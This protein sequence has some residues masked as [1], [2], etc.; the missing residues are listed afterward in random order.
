LIL[1]EN[2]HTNDTTWS[3]RWSLDGRENISHL[4]KDFNPAVNDQFICFYADDYPLPEDPP[5]ITFT[6]SST[7]DD[8][9]VGP[10]ENITLQAELTNYDN[11]TITATINI[12][13]VSRVDDDNAVLDENGVYTLQYEV[14]PDDI[15]GGAVSWL[16][17]ITVTNNSGSATDGR[18]GVIDQQPP[19]LETKSILAWATIDSYPYE[20][21]TLP[22]AVVAV[23]EWDGINSVK[24]TFDKSVTINGNSVT[25]YTVTES[26]WE[27]VFGTGQSGEYW[28]AWV[29]I[30]TW[31]TAANDVTV[32]SVGLGFNQFDFDLSSIN[33]L[34]G[35]YWASFSGN[36]GLY[37]SK[38]G[39][40][41][42]T[43]IQQLNNSS[44][45][46][47][48]NNYIP[49]QLN[50]TTRD[51]PEPSTLAIFALGMIGLA[52]RRFKKQS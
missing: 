48:T 12:D 11:G 14:T 51:V 29:D 27:D 21:D 13:G 39:S 10:G 19:E 49:F 35:T 52:S 3:Q 6:L 28:V 9:S 22:V 45:S 34:A 40:F 46:L 43:M 4:S 23:N 20:G 31:A 15:T 36:S 33:L 37:G 5:T 32:T 17:E 2:D 26:T 42:A 7:A 8:A 50:G 41:G 24:F 38:V 30:G 44:N 18:N 1:E 16:Y 47:R 25:E